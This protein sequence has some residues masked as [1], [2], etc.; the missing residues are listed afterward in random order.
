MSK[1]TLKE[2]VA[3]ITTSKP[4]S[5]KNIIRNIIAVGKNFNMSYQEVMDLP[6]C[7][8]NEYLDILIE[9]NKKQ[10]KKKGLGVKHG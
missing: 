9:D 6:V 7:A 2:K 8:F 4:V 1:L 5:D 3:R 10:K